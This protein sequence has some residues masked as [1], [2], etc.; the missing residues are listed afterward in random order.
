MLKKRKI[1]FLKKFIKTPLI[2]LAYRFLSNRKTFLYEKQNFIQAFLVLNQPQLIYNFIIFLKKK[3]GK[4]LL[5]IFFY[6]I[7]T[8]T[9]KKFQYN[10]LFRR[11]L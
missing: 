11:K 6:K 1:F 7:F 10:F 9:I 2:V 5:N 3:K 8:Q 4:L